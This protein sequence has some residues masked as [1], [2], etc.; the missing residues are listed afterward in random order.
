LTGIKGINCVKKNFA[1]FLPSPNCD[2]FSR[3]RPLL[4]GKRL[5]EAKNHF[6]IGSSLRNMLAGKRKQKYITRYAQILGGQM[7]DML[8]KSYPARRYQVSACLSKEF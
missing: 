4:K 3:H 6:F 2:K 8:S 5:T 1:S 7:E